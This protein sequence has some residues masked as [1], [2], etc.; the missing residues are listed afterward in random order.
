M[1][2]ASESKES[3]RPASS[4]G[5]GTEKLRRRTVWFAVSS[6]VILALFWRPL[7]LVL[8]LS[9]TRDEYS[10]IPL[11]PL[12][13]LCL[14]VWRRRDFFTEVKSSPR[15]G[16]AALVLGLALAVVGVKLAPVLDR[17]DDLCW[18]MAALALLCLGAFLFCYG[19]AAFRKALFPLLFLLLI[20][21]IPSQLLDRII[22]WLQEA[23]SNV[24]YAVFNF[25]GVPVFRRGFIFDLPG[26]SIEVAKEC[27]GIH[28]T[29]ALF[30]TSLLA[31]YLLIP[32]KIGR[33]LLCLTVVPIAIFKNGVRIVTLSTLTV[34]VDPNVING[35][36]HHK[37]GVVFF[38]PAL[39]VLGLEI[40]LLE[41]L[42][43][44]RRLA[45]P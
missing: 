20:I 12:V 36:L 38:I 19:R 21:P 9:R 10:Y 29:L 17:N 5:D 15:L 8:Q 25:I 3:A 37:G 14:V 39:L 41:K 13:S 22:Q 30:I 1:Q 42:E 28:S 33:V 4:A 45:Y 26:L 18:K 2:V 32:S 44:R 43:K 24:S 35:P 16:A 7:L 23:S 11:I 40:W 34:Y 27:S 31:G 6:A